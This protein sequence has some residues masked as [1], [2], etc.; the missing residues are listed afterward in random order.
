MDN[1]WS[2][3]NSLKNVIA[4]LI[5]LANILL[6]IIIR[7]SKKC[8][9]QVGYF[10]KKSDFKQLIRAEIQPS[11]RLS[12]RDRLYGRHHVTHQHAQDRLLEVRHR[13]VSPGDHHGGRL[14]LRVYQQLCP[15]QPRP[16]AVSEISAELQQQD[17]YKLED[18][19]DWYR[20]C[21]S[22]RLLP[23]HPHV[24]PRGA[25]HKGEHNGWKW[26]S[27]CFSI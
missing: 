15:R 8:R 14:A 18:N 22:R 7:T 19:Q 4:G 13:L 24:D 27:L 1:Y 5:I 10:V 20:C 17:S 9:K 3:R 23:S 6:I 12:G 11:D 25:H 16:S 21:L 26:T 2:W